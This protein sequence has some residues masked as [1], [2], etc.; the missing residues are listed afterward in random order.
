M[1]PAGPV[2]VALSLDDVGAG[3]VGPWV[4]VGSAVVGSAVVGVGGVTEGA[5]HPGGSPVF[6]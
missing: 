5:G 6:P 3:P 4:V 2:V 1:T